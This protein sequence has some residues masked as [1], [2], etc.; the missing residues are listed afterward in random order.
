MIRSIADN[1]DG[2]VFVAYRL[3]ADTGNQMV[4]AREFD[5]KVAIPDSGIYQ[6]GKSVALFR[7]NPLRQWG[8]GTNTQTCVVQMHGEVISRYGH[9]LVE[10]LFKQ[11]VD[12]SLKTGKELIASGHSS[13]RLTSKFW[14]KLEDKNISLFRG[15]A[16]IGSWSFNKFF[17][18][19][20]GK[21]LQ[22]EVKD[23][24]GV[25]NAHT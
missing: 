18:S 21:I 24:F 19:P 2:R 1:G 22:E 25:F 13:V 3:A 4:D 12:V 8:E 14:L 9:E 20:E 10:H 15:N 5:I 23:Q 16:R 6:C 17:W 11:Q 7:R